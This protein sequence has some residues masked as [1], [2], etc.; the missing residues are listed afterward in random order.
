MMTTTRPSTRLDTI[1]TRQRNSRVRDA[2]FAV[3]ITL[4]A[5]VGIASVNAASHAASTSQVAQR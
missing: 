3:C 4:A 2:L 1:V 5:A